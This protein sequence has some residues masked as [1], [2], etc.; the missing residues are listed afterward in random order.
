MMQ[1]V[2]MDTPRIAKRYRVTYWDSA[3]V[4]AALALGRFVRHACCPHNRN[5]SSLAAGRPSAY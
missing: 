5:G 1:E 3:I 2:L 4:A